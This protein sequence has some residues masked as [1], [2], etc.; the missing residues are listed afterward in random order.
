MNTQDDLERQLG[1]QLSRRA[2]GI[3]GSPLSMDD[4]LG[5]AGQIRRNRRLAAGVGV[6]AALAVIVPIAITAGGALESKKDV[7]PARPS[8]PVQIARTELTLDGL[9]RGEDPGVEYFTPDGVVLPDEGLQPLD[10]RY[11]ALVPVTADGSWLAWDRDGL[12]LRSHSESFEPQ[13]GSA[14]N[15]TFVSNSDRSLVAW[16]FPETG[17]QTLIM[18]S[19]TNSDDTVVWDFP[20]SPA[21]D[22]VDFAGDRAVLYQ[23]MSE[24]ET[25]TIGLAT[26]GTDGP[27][28]VELTGDFVKAISADDV[29]GLVAVQTRTN[30][31]ASGCFGVLDTRTDLRTPIWETCDHS[32]DEFSPDGRYLLAS[33]PQRS[34]LGIPSLDIVD[35]RTG[36]L[37]ASF[38]PARGSQL[39]LVGVV[40]ESAETV[41]AVATEGD[42]TTLL[43]FGVDGSLEEAV[44]RLSGV[45]IFG[46]LPIHLGADRRRAF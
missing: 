31:D 17:A 2:S 42:E 28:T 44:D 35:A 14:T 32:L 19:T 43:R 23:T 20:D 27:E 18:K 5:R 13:S 38:T 37:A 12:D 39:Q 7:D 25:D 15:G 36:V 22:P 10:R 9:E 24:G 21:V 16:T 33:S 1:Q 4:V 6:A 8:P 26:E 45:D 3:D 41:L 34:G 30:K 11:D 46:D 40:W 29:N